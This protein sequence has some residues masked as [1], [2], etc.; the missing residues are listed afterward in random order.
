MNG[1]GGG[2][3]ETEAKQTKSVTKMEFG[4]ESR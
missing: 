4:K 1:N 3:P 2:L